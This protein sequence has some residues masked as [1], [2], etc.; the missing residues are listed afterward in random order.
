MPSSNQRSVRRAKI[1][2]VVPSNDG[3]FRF[4]ARLTDSAAAG[5]FPGDEITIHDFS[6]EGEIAGPDLTLVS[7]ETRAFSHPYAECPF[8]APTAQTLVGTSIMS[9]WRKA[10]LAQLGGVRGCTH[11]NTLLLGLGELAT[12]VFFLRINSSV[13]YT[14]QA[15]QD[16]RWTSE[17]LQV[18]PSLDDVCWGLRHEGPALRAGRAR[19]ELT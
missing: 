15:R 18:A 11:V 19:T 13:P 2:D 14:P 6:L 8:V 5:D 10:V 1:M 17:A 3:A 16:G 9:G 12:M 7:L 4:V